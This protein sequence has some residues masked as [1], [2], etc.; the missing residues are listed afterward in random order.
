MNKFIVEILNEDGTIRR[1]ETF[2][3]LK[4]ICEEY[5][6]HRYQIE[7]ID[8]LKQEDQPEK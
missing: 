2:K 8:L 4:E 6:P 7:I 1:S 3:N 5:L